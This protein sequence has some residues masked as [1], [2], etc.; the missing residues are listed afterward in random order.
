MLCNKIVLMIL[1]GIF[2]FILCG[3]HAAERTTV[4]C[5]QKDCCGNDA[6]TDVPNSAVADQEQ[7]VVLCTNNKL[8]TILK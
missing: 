6:C 7:K 1:E 2:I 4:G 8:L 3:V 5:A